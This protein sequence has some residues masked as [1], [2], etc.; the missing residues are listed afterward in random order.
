[1]AASELQKLEIFYKLILPWFLYPKGRDSL[2]GVATDYGLDGLGIES[3]WGRDF[4][5]IS[6]PALKP[7]QHPVQWVPCLSRG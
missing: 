6:T 7:T 1:M 5:H 2:A 4:W 3:R